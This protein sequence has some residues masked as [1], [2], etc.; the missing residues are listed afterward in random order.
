GSLG[1]HRA[2]DDQPGAHGGTVTARDEHASDLVEGLPQ[3]PLR[4]VGPV[5]DIARQDVEP[6]AAPEEPRIAARRTADGA[7][8]PASAPTARAAAVEQ[9]HAGPPAPRQADPAES[10]PPA[11]PAPTPAP[12]S[13]PA[14]EPV[15]EPE[16]AAEE[17]AP[18]KR[19]KKGKPVMP[20][21]DEVLLG[22]RGQR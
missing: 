12:P 4:T 17:P 7:E 15:A 9:R 11:Q 3:R 14:P 22:V 18:Q 20:S 13:V 8:R 6:P 10:G 5:I 19:T 1:Q 16:A 21:W 2:L